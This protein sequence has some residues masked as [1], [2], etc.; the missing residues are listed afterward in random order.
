M[1]DPAPH[2]AG[3][4][5]S[6]GH[7][8]HAGQSH[9]GG[10]SDRARAPGDRIAMRSS[11]RD[12]VAVTISGPAARPPRCANDTAEGEQRGREGD[13]PAGCVAA[14]LGHGGPG[15]P[16]DADGRAGPEETPRPRSF[17]FGADGGLPRASG[18]GRAPVCHHA[19][20]LALGFCRRDGWP[21][22]SWASG[23][24]LPVAPVPPPPQRP[25]R[26]GRAAAPAAARASPTL[27]P[28]RC[29]MRGCS[30][31]PQSHQLQQPLAAG[32]SPGP[33]PDTAP[34]PRST[35]PA[36][37]STTARVINR[38][39]RSQSIQGD[40]HRRERFCVATAQS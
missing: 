35:S 15:G 3:G 10:R 27:R 4:R 23:R 31:P 30:S 33:L 19:R 6:A 18:N 28:L 1:G 34:T 32:P 11:D 14:A 5:P 8:G 29:L 21:Q 17:I 13:A 7:D 38:R 40:S 2:G 16:D 12:T 37:T 24:F 20:R 36:R 9:E 39:P 22:L 26:R 25:P